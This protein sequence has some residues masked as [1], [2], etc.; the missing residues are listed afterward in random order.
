M[1]RLKVLLTLLTVFVITIPSVKPFVLQ[2]Y[3]TSDNPNGN[4]NG[5][6]ISTSQS[7]LRYFDDTSHNFIMT[8]QRMNN[9]NDE[10][11][12]DERWDKAKIKPNDI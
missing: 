4:P 12:R 2:V 9:K 3:S 10:Q 8:D 11:E 7:Q 6:K 1:F 5:L